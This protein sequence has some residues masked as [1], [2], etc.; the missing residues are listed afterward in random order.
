MSVTFRVLRHMQLA[1]SQLQEL[2]RSLEICKSM[3]TC[4]KFHEP[5]LEMSRSHN[6]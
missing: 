1:L 5:E 6:D 2:L 4:N 3:V